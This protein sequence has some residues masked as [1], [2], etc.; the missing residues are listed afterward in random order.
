M[1][2]KRL[3]WQC[4]GAGR[5]LG[6][7]HCAALVELL[8]LR[9]AQDYYPLAALC[10]SL[11]AY[12]VLD[13]YLRDVRKAHVQK[14]VV[15]R[16]EVELVKA[17][18]SI[19]HLDDPKILEIALRRVNACYV[20]SDKM[21]PFELVRD[22]LTLA[23]IPSSLAIF[24]DPHE[25]QATLRTH[26][27]PRYLFTLQLLDDFVDMEED[28]NNLN[29]NIFLFRIPREAQRRVIAS[30]PL[31]LRGLLSLVR[32]EHE[33]LNEL[34]QEKIPLRQYEPSILGRTLVGGIGW[35][36]E[37]EARYSQLPFVELSGAPDLAAWSGEEAMSAVAGTHYTGPS[38]DFRDVSA[39]AIHT[40][41]DR[42]AEN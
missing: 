8:R 40:L 23:Y 7:L 11:R 9:F 18:S 24:V 33:A 12:V 34:M 3:R 26:V 10:Q 42:R 1:N 39:E 20:H 32:R 38:V 35:C 2:V 6:A 37:R 14:S 31:L 15:A 25:V 36:K 19:A 5:F 4:T 28:C 27:V 22:K 30:R 29:H 16:T 17:R 21:R 13:D 41:G